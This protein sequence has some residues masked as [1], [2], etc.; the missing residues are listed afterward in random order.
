MRRVGFWLRLAAYF[1]DLL[2]MIP[3]MF[4]AFSL[5]LASGLP[6]RQ[7]EQ[8]ASDI[9][10]TFFLIYTM[11]EFVFAGT[12]GKRIFAI[13]IA[14]A[15][16]TPADRWTRFF[17]WTTK[18]FW[19]IFYLVYLLSFPIR[20]SNIAYLISGFSS[21]CFSIG[22]LYAL[23]DEKQAWHD[24]WTSTAVFRRRDVLAATNRPA[25]TQESAGQ[26]G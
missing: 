20:L 15:D 22:C 10:F 23:N 4:A 13:M 3:V 2:L 24:Q 16:G 9:W 7:A 18:Q 11:C 5:L 26:L 12:L 25:P 8:A 1:I 19:A 17:R 14:N 6:N 21:L